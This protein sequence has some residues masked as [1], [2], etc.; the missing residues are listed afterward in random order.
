MKLEL[1]ADSIKKPSA[2]TIFQIGERCRAPYQGFAPLC[3]NAFC[4][5]VTPFRDRS[6]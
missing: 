6:P 4:D 3:E 5:I 2:L 1:K